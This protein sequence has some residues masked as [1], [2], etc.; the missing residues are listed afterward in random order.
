MTWN[1]VAEW[2]ISM[3]SMLK[4]SD[5]G[6]LFLPL[7]FSHWFF[8]FFIL[9]N[10]KGGRVKGAYRCADSNYALGFHFALYLGNWKMI[11]LAF[12]LKLLDHQ[13]REIKMIWMTETSLSILYFIRCFSTSSSTYFDG[14]TCSQSSISSI[15]VHIV[16]AM[17]YS[18]MFAAGKHH[19]H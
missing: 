10:L 1:W 2:L 4:H 3:F 5:I 17:F 13:K 8:V 6:M 19:L 12:S 15:L 14:W 16:F 7:V 18:S 11:A 9:S